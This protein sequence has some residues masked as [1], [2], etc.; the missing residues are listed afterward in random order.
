MAGRSK[1]VT[2]RSAANTTVYARRVAA[3]GAREEERS[4]VPLLLRHVGIFG[5]VRYG[6]WLWPGAPGAT[7]DET[8]GGGGLGLNFVGVVGTKGGRGGRR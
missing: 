1:T 4:G 5:V 2:T 3:L 7:D 8:G 6:K